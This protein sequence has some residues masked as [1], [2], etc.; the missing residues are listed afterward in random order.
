MPVDVSVCVEVFANDRADYVGTAVDRE[1]SRRRVEN[2]GKTGSR[3]AARIEIDLLLDARITR[4]D[5]VDLQIPGIAGV[6]NNVVGLC[7][8]V[9]GKI[10]FEM[11]VVRDS[12][13]R[14]LT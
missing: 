4:T 8:E 1:I 12:D 7:S 2:R 14:A 11:D 13:R 10:K 9:A 6:V 5:S 3:A